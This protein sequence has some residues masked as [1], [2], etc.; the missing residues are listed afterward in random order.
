MSTIRALAAPQAHAKLEA[1][2]F[3]PGPLGDEQVEI[4]VQYCGIC[5]SDLSML[6]NEWHITRYP[7]V[8]GHEAVGT[9]SAVGRS[10]KLVGPGQTVGL[11]WNAGSCMSCPPCLAGD[12]NMCRVL[13]Q[14]IVGRHGAF[15]TRVRCHWSWATPIPPALDPSAAGPLFCGGITVFNPLVQHNVRPTDRVGVIGV[16]GSAALRRDHGIQSAGAAPRAAHGPRGRDRN[17]RVGPHG[18]AIPQQMGLRRNRVHQF[19]RQGG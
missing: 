13:E 1:F 9:V 6:H 17:R 4:D 12:H 5:H 2:T 18:A 15:A 8:P 7:F 14:T 3:D 16:G 11:G 19:G 10:A